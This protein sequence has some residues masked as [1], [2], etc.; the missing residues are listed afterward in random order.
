M[1]FERLSVR[2]SPTTPSLPDMIA[3]SYLVCGQ[4]LLNDL[5]PSVQTSRQV[6]FIP[7]VADPK[8]EPV[9]VSADASGSFCQLLKPG[10]YKLEPMV[11]ETEVAAGL[12]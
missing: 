12:K 1:G 11:L 3:S 4:I 8:M 7:A 10:Q 6:V 9:I 2:I 5:P